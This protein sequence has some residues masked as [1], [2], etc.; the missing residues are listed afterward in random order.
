MCVGLHTITDIHPVHVNLLIREARK[1]FDRLN[2]FRLPASALNSFC[3]ATK[4]VHMLS[5]LLEPK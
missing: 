5:T 4:L 1:G 2:V 3:N